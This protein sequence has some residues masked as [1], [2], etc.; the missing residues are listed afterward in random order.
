M[1]LYVNGRVSVGGEICKPVT[2]CPEKFDE[3]VKLV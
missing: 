3:R 1:I 2:A